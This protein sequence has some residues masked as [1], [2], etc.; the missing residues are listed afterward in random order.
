MVQKGRTNNILGLPGMGLES[1]IPVDSCSKRAEK[2][3]STLGFPPNGRDLG[4]NSL[5]EDVVS[6]SKNIKDSW[7][8][9]VD[10]KVNEDLSVDFDGSINESLMDIQSERE[11]G[12]CFCLGQYQDMIFLEEKLK[13]CTK[14]FLLK[15][16]Q[17]GEVEL[18]N[19]CGFLFMLRLLLE[20]LMVCCSSKKVM[21]CWKV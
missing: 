5:R 3:L 6:G 18:E 4:S 16:F 11:S 19:D 17:E 14:W 10:D 2:D 1:Q 9:A 21:E 13:N 7:T 20:C 8:K 12:G 15:R